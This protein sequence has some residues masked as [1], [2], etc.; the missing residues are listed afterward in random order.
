MQELLRGM[1]LATRRFGRLLL[2]GI[3]AGALLAGV[4]QPSAAQLSLPDFGQTNQRNPPAEV[5]RLGSIE[6]APVRSPI[7]GEELFLV[8]SPTVVNRG[9]EGAELTA[10]V[11]TRAEEI[12]ARLLRATL[13]FSKL[14]R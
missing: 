2:T 14:D 10:A 1:K 5:T 13:R 6:V 3:L 7:S 12:S 9:V 11:E 4:I 8:A